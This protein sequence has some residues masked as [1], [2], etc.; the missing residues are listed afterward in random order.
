MRAAGSAS[1]EL[2]YRGC[3][4]PLDEPELACGRCITTK[5]A[6]VTVIIHRIGDARGFDVHVPRS[7]A[8][9]LWAWLAEAGRDRALPIAASSAEASRS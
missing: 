1:T 7:L 9:S 8:Q 3:S 2:L 4:T 5:L 6:K